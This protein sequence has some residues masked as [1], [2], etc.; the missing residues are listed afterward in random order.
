MLGARVT[1]SLG[2]TGNAAVYPA[3]YAI[4]KAGL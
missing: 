1:L 4:Q 2:W 3:P